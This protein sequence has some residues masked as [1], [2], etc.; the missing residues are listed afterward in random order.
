MGDGQNGPKSGLDAS[1][2]E[3]IANHVAHPIFVKDRTFSFVFVND[4]FVKMLGFPR[5]QLLGKSD[6]DFFPKA[7]A[8][9]FRAKDIEMFASGEKIVIDEEPITD[10]E[11][12]KHVLATTKVPMLDAAGNI[13]H[14]VGIIHDITNL[15]AAEEELRRMNAAL[16]ERVA[17]RTRALSAA[18]DDLVRKERLAVLGSLAG[19]VAHQIRNPLASIKTAGHVLRDLTRDAEEPRIAETVAIIQEEVGR[20][21]RIVTDLPDYARVRTPE[22]RAIKAAF[23]VEQVLGAYAISDAIQVE[24]CLDDVLDVL[25]DPEQ[26][27]GALGN[28]VRNAVEAACS[29]DAIRTLRVSSRAHGDTLHIRISDSGPGV[30]PG[31]RAHLFE[32]LFTTKTSGLGLGLVTARS[33]IENQGGRVE[34]SAVSELGGATF[35]VFLPLASAERDAR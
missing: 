23:L 9:F 33:L 11:G 17:E 6:P 5:E 29:N 2:F 13:T 14:L 8:D 12:R 27:Q 3:L 31:I 15:K 25:V 34:L 1:F 26:T 16:E 32:P 4:A 30:A 22:K 28:I 19:G 20:A 7:E 21:N 35:D 18:Q 10:A 24:R